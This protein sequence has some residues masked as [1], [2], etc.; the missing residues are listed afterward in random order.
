[1][2]VVGRALT[3]RATKKARESFLLTLRE[4]G[5]ITAACRAAGISR[6]TAYRWRE[7][8]PEFDKWWDAALD[9]STDHLEEVAYK[10]AEEQSDLLL[11]FLLKARRPAL[12]REQVQHTVA[13]DIHLRYE[14]DWRAV[15]GPATIV[16]S[17]VTSSPDASQQ[18]PGA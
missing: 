4:C 8:D 3:I 17:T 1:M 11:M 6:D 2:A 5:N 18:Q 10:R 12:Y 13:G 9:A 14:N 15:G 7:Q 16:E